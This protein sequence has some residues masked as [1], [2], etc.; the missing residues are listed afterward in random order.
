MNKSAI[1]FSFQVEDDHVDESDFDSTV[2]RSM[3]QR[4]QALAEPS[5]YISPD[6]LDYATLNLKQ[7]TDVPKPD[8]L[9]ETAFQSFVEVRI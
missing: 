6:D 7:L 9:N 1:S 4:M 3:T 2:V 5:N 8:R